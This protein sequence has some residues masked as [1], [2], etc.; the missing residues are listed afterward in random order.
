MQASGTVGEIPLEIES[1]AKNALALVQI[2][3]SRPPLSKRPA[4]VL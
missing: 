4:Y 2:P 1:H 3:E